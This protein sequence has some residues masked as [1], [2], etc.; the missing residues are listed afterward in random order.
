VK[1]LTDPAASTV[2]LVARR[3]TVRALN[4]L[5]AP[6]L[7]ADNTT[8]LPVERQ[9]YR[10]TATFVKYKL[11]S[12]Q[13][14]HVIIAASGKTM[15]AEMPSVNCDRGARARHAM[16]VARQ[17]LESRYGPATDQWTYVGQRATLTGVRFFDFKHGQTG[18]ADNAVEL[19]P[20]FGF[21]R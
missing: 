17:K 12:D 4:A 1:R 16:L 19:H 9:S 8:R 6:T 18:V 21:K 7:P 15:I 20:V 14:I 2:R 13:D 10:V 11:E 5:P 3:S